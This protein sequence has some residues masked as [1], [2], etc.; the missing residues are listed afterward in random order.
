MAEIKVQRKTG[1]PW[2]LLL[3]LAVLAF[4]LIWW[5]VA[6][7]G[8]ND[9][10]TD[11]LAEAPPAATAPGLAGGDAGATATGEPAAGDAVTDVNTILNAGD[12]RTLVGRDVRLEDVAV[13]EMVGDAAFWIGASGGERVLVILDQQIPSPPPS[14]EGRVNVNAGQTVDVRGRMRA[15]T[16][17]PPAAGLEPREREAARGQQVYIWAD[18]AEVV[19]PA[20][21]APAGPPGR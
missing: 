20:S 12:A 17:L 5:L 18:S 15:A 14:V 19:S 7:S 2:W 6:R 16:D 11:L 3:L 10:D 9:A 1:V 13:Q 8:N 4:G 21:A